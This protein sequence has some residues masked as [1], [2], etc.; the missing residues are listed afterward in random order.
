MC[1][2]LVIPGLLFGLLFA[3]G[4]CLI[5]AETSLPMWLNWQRMQ[6]WRP[7]SAQL[8]SFS[9]ADNRTEARYR[10]DFAGASYQGTRVGVSEV[11]D[12]IGSFHRDMR[13]R[14]TR[15]KRNGDVL[16]IWVNP[17]NPQD[18][19]IDRNMR[20]GLFA[21]ATGFC[22]VFILI[23]SIV[24]FGSMRGVFRAPARRQRRLRKTYYQAI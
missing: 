23:G 6:Y 12:N 16:P 19:V 14:L 7:A 17:A 3:G 15:I 18:S 5:L 9:V 10:Y 22:S 21:L 4:G 2:L 1:R 24:V 11:K 20:W 8:S 13:H